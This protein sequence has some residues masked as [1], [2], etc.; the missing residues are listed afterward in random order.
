MALDMGSKPLILAR[1]TFAGECEL[2][3]AAA[4]VE[5]LPTAAVVDQVSI[6]PRHAIL[7]ENNRACI[8]KSHQRPML[9]SA[10]AIAAIAA[11][12]VRSHPL[13]AAHPPYAS[14]T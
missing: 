4:A 7:L 13:S 5:E 12:A 10:V 8:L 9:L 11:A 2:P 6:N 1:L 3:A 14:T